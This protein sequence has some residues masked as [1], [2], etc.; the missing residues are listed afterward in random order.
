MK[1]YKGN[2]GSCDYCDHFQSSIGYSAWGCGNGIDDDKFY[3]V[4]SSEVKDFIKSYKSFCEIQL[5]V[6]IEVVKTLKTIKSILPLN[7]KYDD[8]GLSIDDIDKYICKAIL[9]YIK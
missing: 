3:M 1:I 2:Y 6:L 9:D 5:N 4:K 7:V 8:Y